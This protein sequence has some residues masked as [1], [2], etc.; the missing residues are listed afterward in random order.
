MTGVRA[1]LAAPAAPLESLR[2]ERTGD[3]GARFR[4]RTGLADGTSLRLAIYHPASGHRDRSGALRVSDG[5]FRSAPFHEHGF[6]MPSGLYRVAVMIPQAP[7][8][9]PPGPQVVQ[10]ARVRLGEPSRTGRAV[11]LLGARDFSADCPYPTAPFRANF[12][13][14]FH[15]GYGLRREGWSLFTGADDVERLRLTYSFDGRGRSEAI[16][17]VDLAAGAIDYANTEARRFSCH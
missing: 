1:L 6:P 2:V 15:S 14:F 4:G 5:R 3:G 12:D 13:H 8:G 16:W 9:G 7:A 11:A 17:E 10:R